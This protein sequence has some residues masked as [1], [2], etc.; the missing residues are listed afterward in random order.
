[1]E[2]WGGGFG[3]GSY[4]SVRVWNYPDPIGPGPNER[5]RLTSCL[6]SWLRQKVNEMIIKWNATNKKHRKKS[7]CWLA[8]SQM[9]RSLSPS[10]NHLSTK[11]WCKRRREA[12]Q[13]S[14]STTITTDPKASSSSTHPSPSLQNV[15]PSQ[16]TR[17]SPSPCDC[18]MNRLSTG[19]RGKP[20][21]LLVDS[22]FWDNRKKMAITWT[23]VKRTWRRRR[24]RQR[25]A[26]QDGHHGF[27][28]PIGGGLCRV[29]LRLLLAQIKV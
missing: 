10:T 19:E 24:R 9:S 14:D 2:V 21:M 16:P 7:I 18:Q 27:R 3:M 13:A 20:G 25:E 5:G 28:I 6:R 12:A 8:T 1:M 22:S 29:G 11:R 26:I 15:T 17:G 4:Q 23:S